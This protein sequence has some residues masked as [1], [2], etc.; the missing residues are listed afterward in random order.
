MGSAV[1]LTI[2][3][4]NIVKPS[5]LILFGASARMPVAPTLLQGS[6]NA[7]NEVATFIA[8]KGIADAPASRRDVV[9]RCI[10]ATGTMTTFGDFLACNRFDLRGVLSQIGAPTLV[11]AGSRDIMTPLKFSQSLAAGLPMS[12]LLILEDAGHFAMLERPKM[13]LV[14]IEEFLH[15]LAAGNE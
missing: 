8:D 13:A 3:Q 1:A 7:L 6:I 9:H 12:G 5:G 11:I 15:Q 10:L 2:A 4:R 14:A